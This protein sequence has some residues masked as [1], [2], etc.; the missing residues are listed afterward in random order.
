MKLSVSALL[1][2]TILAAA[3]L[4]TAACTVNPVTGEKELSM[5]SQEQEIAIGEKQYQNSQQSQGGLYYLDP[6]LQSYINDIGQQLARVSHRPDLP[7][8]FVVLN[9]GVPNAWALPGGK[10]AINRGLLIHLDDEAELA[11]VLG[12]EIVHAAAGHGAAQMSQGQLLSI[13]AQLAAIASQIGGYGNLGG[14]AAQLGGAAWMAKYGRDDELESDAFGMEYMAKVGYDPQGAVE[15]QQTFVRL[16]N[17]KQTDFVSGLFASHPPSQER[18]KANQ[19]MA[20]TLPAGKRNKD[21]YQQHIAQLK[22][23]Q[24][25]YDAQEKAMKAIKDKK[26]DQ[27]MILIERAIEVQ[28]RESEF[29]EI[30]GQ[31][32][33]HKKQFKQAEQ[34]YSRAVDNNPDYFRPVLL[35]G[36]LRFEQGDHV[37]AAADLQ[38]SYN[39]LPTQ[40]AADHL[41]K[42]K[43]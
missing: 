16:S 32:L 41:N 26:Y 18:V 29:W 6:A 8:E 39:I 9:S 25:A 24:P 31:L 40:I 35:R 30:K 15:L 7:Y 10:L 38:H 34:A 37:A 22:K 17:N 13:G 43:Q 33:E 14:Q 1:L 23:D 4:L 21:R 28:P 36:L 3:L 19:R 12:H 42:L 27:A 5:L 11:A 2:R 20:A